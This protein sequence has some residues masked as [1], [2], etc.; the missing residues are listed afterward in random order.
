MNSPHTHGFCPA[1]EE[2][3]AR[4]Q[5]VGCTIQSGHREDCNDPGCVCPGCKKIKGEIE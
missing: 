2:I 1:C 5:I 3:R 4:T